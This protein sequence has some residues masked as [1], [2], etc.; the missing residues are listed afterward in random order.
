MV[1]FQERSSSSWIQEQPFYFSMWRQVLL[2]FR[3]QSYHAENCQAKE[4]LQNEDDENTKAAQWIFKVRQD[5]GLCECP[6]GGGNGVS[7]KE[8]KERVNVMYN[9]HRLFVTKASVF[10]S[11]SFIPEPHPLPSVPQYVAT[12]VTKGV[13]IRLLVQCLLSNN[14]LN[15]SI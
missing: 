13:V 6:A 3:T 11:F 7:G 10:M 2:Y 1:L 15:T 4:T 8:Q 14:M 5:P 9:S 12:T